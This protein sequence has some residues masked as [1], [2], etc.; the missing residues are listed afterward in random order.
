MSDCGD[1]QKVFVP[2]EKNKEQVIPVKG[3]AITDYAATKIKEFLKKEKK[4]FKK[5]GLKIGVKPDGCSGHSYVMELIEIEPSEKAGDKIFH[6]NGATAIV[7]K[8]GY[9]YV[10]GSTLD[11]I[12]ALTGSGFTIL[13]PNAKNF[14]SCGSSFGV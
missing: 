8:L 1:V 5:F 4:P 6:H 12:D 13:N 7:E 3:L 10:A 11:Y 9:F 14:C 2:P